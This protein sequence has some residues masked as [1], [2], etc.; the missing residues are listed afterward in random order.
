MPASPRSSTAA[1]WSSRRGAA[2][3][4][5]AT[6]RSSSG[7]RPTTGSWAGARR[8]R[9]S[10][11]RSPRRSSTTCS[12]RSIIGEDPRAVRVLWH[13]MTES[14]RERG[15]LQGHQADAM[16]A[17]DIALWDLWGRATGLSVSELAGGRFAEILPAYVSG[18]RG[19]DDAERAERGRRARRRRR[20]PHQ[21]APR[22]RRRH[23]PGDLRRHPGG[24]P[25]P[26]TSRSTRTGP[27]GSARPALSGASSTS[28]APGSSR[29]PSLPRTSR[30]TA[31]SPPPSTRRSRSAR[32]C[33]AA[34]SS[35]TGSSAAPSSL[36]QPDIGRTGITEGLAIAALAERLPRTG[37]AAP[38]G[39]VRRRD[40][41]RRARRGRVPGAPRVRVP[42]GHPAGGEPHPDHAAG[43]HAGRLVPGAARDR[44]WASRS[45][46]TWSESSSGTPDQLSQGCRPVNLLAGEHELR[47]RLLLDVPLAGV[48]D[49]HVRQ[50]GVA[51]E[52]RPSRGCRTRCWTGRSARS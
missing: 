35:P 32:R 34:S 41:G 42:A 50:D 1:T 12:P 3:T 21:A 22:H 10:R 52:R 37:R 51:A 4:R 23:R 33:A 40:G 30:G 13:R 6:R 27:T 7:S 28:G 26:A 19:A 49:G 44:A 24:A 38:L 46:R 48:G 11:P 20:A 2:S 43:G 18:I 16:A 31:T 45:T 25:R 5:P 39:G 36:I 15:H 47:A 17:V 14:M 29:R 8:S 9:R